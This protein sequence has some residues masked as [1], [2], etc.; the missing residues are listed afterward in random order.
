MEGNDMVEGSGWP[1][2]D[3]LEPAKDQT[4]SGGNSCCRIF[5]V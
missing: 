2:G 1:A 5:S 4:H 3:M